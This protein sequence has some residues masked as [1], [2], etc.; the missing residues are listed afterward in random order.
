MS[1]SL[2]FLKITIVVGCIETYDSQMNGS[3]FPLIFFM[4]VSERI[5]SQVFHPFIGDHF[6]AAKAVTTIFANNPFFHENQCSC[7][8]KQFCGQLLVFFSQHLFGLATC[9]FSTWFKTNGH[10]D[11]SWPKKSIAKLKAINFIRCLNVPIIT[12]F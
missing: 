5:Q 8:L 9:H 1:I 3:Y 12:I 7:H 2:T 10:F 11:Q 4:M 6:H